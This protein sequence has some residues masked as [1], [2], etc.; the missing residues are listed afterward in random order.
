MASGLKPPPKECD[1]VSENKE[2]M[3]AAIL[4]NSNTLTPMHTR[5]HSINDIPEYVSRPDIHMRSLRQAPRCARP[6]SRA[7]NHNLR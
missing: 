1:A 2:T 7:N 6:A 5:P 3:I 4:T